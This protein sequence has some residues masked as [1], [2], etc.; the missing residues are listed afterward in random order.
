LEAIELAKITIDYDK[1]TSCHTCTEVCPVGVYEIQDDK[2]V[3]VNA[4]E[5]ILCR[6]CETQ[7]PTEAITVEEE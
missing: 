2:P 4:D 6:A 7:C 5:C 3:P 1:C